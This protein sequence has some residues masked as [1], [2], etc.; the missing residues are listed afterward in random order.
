MSKRIKLLFFAATLCA[1]ASI[2]Q[3]QS[4]VQQGKG[5]QYGPWLVA[6]PDGTTACFSGGGGGG[7]D[8]GGL[9]K[10]LDSTGSTIT[11][12]AAPYGQ[13]YVTDKGQ[14]EVSGINAN[15]QAV[16]IGINIDALTFL[17]NNM[18]GVAG[19][20]GVGNARALSVATRGQTAGANVVAVGALSGTNTAM[21]LAAGLPGDS[22]SGTNGGVLAVGGYDSTSTLYAIPTTRFATPSANVGVEI[23]GSDSTGTT[24]G[25]PIVAG[26]DTYS[27]FQVVVGGVDYNSNLVWPIPVMLQGNSGVDHGVIVSGSSGNGN[28]I[29]LPA[30]RDGDSPINRSVMVG[31]TSKNGTPHTATIAAS[32]SDSVGDA[33]NLLVGGSDSSQVSQALNVVRASN[34][35]AESESSPRMQV[36][37]GQDAF[38]LGQ[39]LPVGVLGTALPPYAIPISGVDNNGDSQPLPISATGAYVANLTLNV[40]GKDGAGNARPLGVARQ[41]S[42]AGENVLTVGGVDS[43]GYAQPLGINANG[44]AFNFSNLLGIAA[45]NGSGDTQALGGATR[46]SPYPN[47]QGILAVGGE[48]SSFNMVPFGN[49]SVGDALPPYATLIGAKDQSGNLAALGLDSDGS[50]FVNDNGGIK[51]YE[52]TSASGGDLNYGPIN[53]SGYKEAFVHFQYVSGTGSTQYQINYTNGA[54]ISY[55]VFAKTAT[56][57]ANYFGGLGGATAMP[58]GNE[59]PNTSATIP[60]PLLLS[61]KAKGTTGTV[62]SYIYVELRK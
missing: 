32:S 37:G 22:M 30:T 14:M 27:G 45:V 53:T 5:G 49:A 44:A 12:A 35:A 39:V 34:P 33:Y 13:P 24:H 58:P 52:A 1:G 60:L 38:G 54:G 42:G 11:Y 57:A 10:G 41:G 6:C 47:G 4:V 20:D 23:S 2:A 31:G 43:S 25:L 16:P 48:N 26:A 7:T 50:V 19:V 8:G 18:I 17:S 56:T 62:V 29:V 40:G 51:A 28:A 61:V 46:F 59:I 3:T 36:I 15:G 9:I 21:G 55:A